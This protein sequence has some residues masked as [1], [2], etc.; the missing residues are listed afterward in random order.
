MRINPIS[1]YIL[2][3]SSRGRWT[4]A[5]IVGAGVCHLCSERLRFG[6]GRLLNLL[7]VPGAI[8]ETW[9][10]DK[11][12]GRRISISVGR[13]FVRVSVDERDYFFDRLTGRFDGT[14][15]HLG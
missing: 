10:R 6:V 5:L 12:S 4:T 7:H 11:V 2:R 9:F 13:R 3:F 1:A 8:R 15:P 14:G